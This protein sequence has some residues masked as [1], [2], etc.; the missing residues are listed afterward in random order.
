M[1]VIL[2]KRKREPGL[3]VWLLQAPLAYKGPFFLYNKGMPSFRS[4]TGFVYAAQS[5]DGWVKIG[6]T[7][8]MPY[9]R[10]QSLSSTS[11]RE[12]FQ[13]VQV[14]HAWDC[15]SLE[16]AAHKSLQDKGFSRQKE[17]FKVD[18]ETLN[19]VFSEIALEN[20]KNTLRYTEDAAI[21]FDPETLS[22]ALLEKMRVAGDASASFLLAHHLVKT[23]PYHAEIMYD[24]ATQQGHDEAFLFHAFLKSFRVPSEHES[25]CEKSSPFVTGLREGSFVSSSVS[26][27]IQAEQDSWATFPLRALPWR[28][29]SQ[30]KV[31]FPPCR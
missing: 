29:L 22:L 24:V 4:R 11:S 9:K 26:D 13:L 28:P 2:K 20:E 19:A 18:A 15:V 10:L 14:Q 8:R 3:N 23:H 17:F 31:F 16:K 7:R 30:K 27:L 12:G 21:S 1:T 5:P 6:F 25:F